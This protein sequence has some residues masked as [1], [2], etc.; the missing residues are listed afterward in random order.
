MKRK[1]GLIVNPIAG[2]GGRVGLKGTDGT[3]ILKRAKEFGASPESPTRTIEALRGLT[4]LQNGIDL[5]TYPH[6][7]GENEAKECGF[8]P[9][10]I[11]SIEKG[12]TT[13]SDTRRAAKELLGI[14]VDLLVF[15]G[16]DGTAKDIY[17]IIGDKI[18]VLGVPA[19]VKIHSAV[20][21]TSPRT[22]G[23]LALMYLQGKTLSLRKAE[24]M[25]IDEDAFRKG[26]VTAELYGYLRIPFEQ[27][28]VQGM[29]MGRGKEEESAVQEIAQFIIDNMEKDCSYIIGPGTTTKAIM[30][31]LGIECT[32]LGV[33][34]ILNKRLIAKDSNETRL[35]K[36]IGGRKTKIIVTII[37]GQ[38]YIFGRG[39]QQISS[40][41]IKKVGRGNVIVI[42]SKNKIV[43]LSGKPLLVDTGDQEVNAMLRGYIKVVT[44]YNE[45]IMVKVVS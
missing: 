23:E 2:M 37:G 7:M 22:A 9:V 29:K 24:V 35:L 43:S 4:P 20:F 33:D 1:V 5:I 14:G 39:N 19:G 32:L 15:A 26:Q 12:A 34:V 27:A 25:D 31:R 41:V 18:T 38:G 28:L 45:R 30:E 42:A 21:A 17:S 40:G 11:G 10:V 6:D 8:N 44:S 13:A 16:G 3:D 36:L